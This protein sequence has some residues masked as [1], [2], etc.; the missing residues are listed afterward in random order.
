M[1]A[2]QM[3]KS[4]LSLVGS[5]IAVNQ[6]TRLGSVIHRTLISEG[7]GEWRA[8]VEE[9]LQNLIR[10][11][12][13]WDGYQGQ[14]VSFTNA[15]F[16]FR[17]LESVCGPYTPA[18]QIVPGADGDLQIEWHTLKGDIELDVRGPN[19]VHAWRLVLGDDTDGEELY[20]RTDFSKI[21]EWIKKLTE[22]VIAPIA[23]AA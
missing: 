12:Q 23:T 21:V 14:P 19:D 17:M 9:R 10:L 3:T 5:P 13:G 22:P 8:Q 7:G 2:Y 6:G 18:P 15:A 20:L 1:G 16:A 11:Q 4:H